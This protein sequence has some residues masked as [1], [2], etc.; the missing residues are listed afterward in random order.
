MTYLMALAHSRTI[1][2]V[3]GSNVDKNSPAIVVLHVCFVVA[4]AVFVYWNVLISNRNIV[5]DV[6]NTMYII[7]VAILSTSQLIIA[8]LFFFQKRRV[9]ALLGE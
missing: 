2:A 8:G 3:T 4:L 6:F 7:A 9:L 5:G 1:N